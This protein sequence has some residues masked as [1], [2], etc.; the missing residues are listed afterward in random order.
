MLQDIHQFSFEWL[1]QMIRRQMEFHSSVRHQSGITIQR[2]L[3]RERFRVS[4]GCAHSEWILSADL[5]YSTSLL[6]LGPCDFQSSFPGQESRRKL[7]LCYPITKISSMSNLQKFLMILHPPAFWHFFIR[8]RC[9]TSWS[10]LLPP[11]ANSLSQLHHRSVWHLLSSTVAPLAPSQSTIPI[12]FP[13]LQIASSFCVLLLHP[14][15][16][17]IFVVLNSISTFPLSNVTLNSMRA[18]PSTSLVPHFRIDVNETSQMLLPHVATDGATR[19]FLLATP[20]YAA[21]WRKSFVRTSQKTASPRGVLPYPCMAL[22]DFS[23][24][25]AMSKRMVPTIVWSCANRFWATRSPVLHSFQIS[26]WQGERGQGNLCAS[27]CV[28]DEW[29]RLYKE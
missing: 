4:T 17:F 27:W 22:I 19:C 23:S 20:W 21:L 6:F 26:A 3:G 1:L 15:L 10:D 12:V 8:S 16:G 24:T 18:P 7:S 29:Q 13:Q 9:S 5:A 2:D 11:S 14:V 28:G 25:T